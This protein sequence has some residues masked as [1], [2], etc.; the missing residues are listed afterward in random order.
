MLI[1]FILKPNMVASDHLE[2]SHIQPCNFGVRA[3]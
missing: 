1:C 3:C 2:P